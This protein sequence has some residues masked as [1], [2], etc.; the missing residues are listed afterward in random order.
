V[1]IVTK[2]GTNDMHGSLYQFLRNN[3][4]DARDFSMERRCRVLNAISLA[5]RQ[6]GP[7][8][9]DKTFL[10]GNFEGFY[11]HHHQTGVD[12]VPDN[13]ARSG[14][15]ASCLLQTQPLPT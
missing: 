11:Q 14:Y 10:F 13:N 1:L 5:A 2:A 12:L 9:K 6:G 15:P 7:V 8:Q 4:L 3:D